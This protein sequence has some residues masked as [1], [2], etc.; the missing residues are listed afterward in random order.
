MKKGDIIKFGN[1]PQDSNG[2]ISPIEW[3]VLDVKENESLLISRYGLD[4]RQYNREWVGITWED[5]N[6]RTN[7]KIK[8]SLNIKL[9]A[10]MTLEIAYSVSALMK[11]NSTSIVIM[12]DY[13]SLLH[14]HEIKVC[15]LMTMAIVTGGFDHR[16]TISVVP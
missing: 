7:L 10:E 4:C 15:M 9:E 16:V 8:D 6:L 12:T 14:T 5:S 2:S 3:L 13:A 11:L 1:Y